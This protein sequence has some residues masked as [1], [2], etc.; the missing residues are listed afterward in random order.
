VDDLLVVEG[1]T[2]VWW[3]TQSGLPK[4]VAT[5]GADCSERQADLIAA[6]VKLVGRVWIMP[7]GDK[8]GERQAQTL[9]GLIAPVR[10]VRWLK[11]ETDKQPTDY[12]ASFFRERMGA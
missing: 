5:M 12:A 11:L 7:D 4:V 3:L 8:A 9:L 2:S 1:F 6:L 10:S